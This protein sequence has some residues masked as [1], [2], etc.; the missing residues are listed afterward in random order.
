MTRRYFLLSIVLVVC[1]A[2]AMEDGIVRVPDDES[3][4]KSEE[5]GGVLAGVMTRGRK[6]HGPVDTMSDLEGFDQ[7]KKIETERLALIQAHMKKVKEQFELPEE[8]L[9]HLEKRLGT[10][11]PCDLATK[12]RSRGKKKPQGKVKPKP[13][14]Q[15]ARVEAE[16][17]GEEE[18]EP[19]DSQ[20]NSIEDPIAPIVESGPGVLKEVIASLSVLSKKYRQE[21]AEKEKINQEANKRSGKLASA[22]KWSTTGGFLVSGLSG[23]G[24]VGMAVYGAIELYLRLTG[25]SC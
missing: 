6:L 23:L 2:Y 21:V 1:G 4:I 8:C 11:Q 13:A 24:G 7:Q 14:P 18:I 22:N 19:E 17:E 5:D 12:G 15:P 20:E 10:L 3:L 25:K 9:P 16:E